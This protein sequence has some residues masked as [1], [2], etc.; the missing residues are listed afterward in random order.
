MATWEDVRRLVAALPGTDEHASYGG[1]PSW[2]VAGKGFVFERPLGEADLATLAR[3]GNPVD[4]P[5]LGA[6]TADEGEKLEL[7]AADPRVYFTIPHFDGYPAV[8]VHLDRIAV[9][10]LAEVVDTAWRSRAPR[11]LLAARDGSST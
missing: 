10:E 2:R 11:R 5:V 9:D 8:L 6:R 4:G 1:R 3:V 7:I